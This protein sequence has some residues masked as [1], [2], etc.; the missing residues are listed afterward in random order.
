MCRNFTVA[1][2]NIKLNLKSPV[3]SGFSAY[4]QPPPIYCW[5]NRRKRGLSGYY[6]YYQS[7]GHKQCE[8]ILYQT[9]GPGLGAN[10]SDH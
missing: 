8:V 1:Y 3:I 4:S 9:P 2:T 5:V 6:H 10:H 7:E